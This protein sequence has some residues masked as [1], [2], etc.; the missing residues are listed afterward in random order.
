[1]IYTTPHPPPPTTKPHTP[2]S[3]CTGRLDNDGAAIADAHLFKKK[4]EVHDVIIETNGSGRITRSE[5]GGEGFGEETSLLP[6]TACYL[7]FSCIIN[8][9]VGF[10]DSPHCESS[11]PAHE[12]SDGLQLLLKHSDGCFTR[13]DESINMTDCF[14]ELRQ[15]AWGQKKK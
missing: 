5:A 9:G 10:K 11:F 4:R 8:A 15:K 1:M 3:K 6:L 14:W 2:R 7:L 12:Q 13:E